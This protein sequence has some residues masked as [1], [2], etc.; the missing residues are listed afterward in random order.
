MKSGSSK[1][2]TTTIKKQQQPITVDLLWKPIALQE[3]YIG[4]LPT[5]SYIF[6]LLKNVMKLTVT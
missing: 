6:F 5:L 2:K 4:F 1:N 3:L